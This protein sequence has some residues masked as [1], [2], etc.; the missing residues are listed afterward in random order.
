MA[1]VQGRKFSGMTN[2]ENNITLLLTRPFD[3]RGVISTQ[4]DL[5]LST[6]WVIDGLDTSYQGIICTVV[7]DS[8]S[9]KN[10][11]YWL[12]VRRSSGI[13]YWEK[14]S[15]DNTAANYH[16]NGWRKL[17]DNTTD[18][19]GGGSTPAT[20]LYFDGYSIGG[21]GTQQD[22]YWVEYVNGGIITPEQ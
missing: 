3:D 18:I 2:Q 17:Y 19:G 5:F 11:V 15:W 12:P 16:V 14:Q 21:N 22:P 4:A 6:T 7:S 9:S 10:G 1:T 8:D 13:N 20:T